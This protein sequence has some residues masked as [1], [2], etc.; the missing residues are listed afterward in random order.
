MTGCDVKKISQLRQK[1][2]IPPE[3]PKSRASPVRRS[4]FQALEER[5]IWT[6]EPLRSTS[7]LGSCFQLVWLGLGGN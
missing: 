7:S 1:T 4:P 2:P 5:H 6:A 3:S